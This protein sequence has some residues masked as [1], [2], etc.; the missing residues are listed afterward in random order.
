MDT[1]Q[2]MGCT[3]VY[4]QIDMSSGP[5]TIILAVG[6]HPAPLV[7]RADGR[8]EV[9][10]AC[11]TMLGAVQ[12]PAF[13]TCEVRLAAGDAIVVYSD[14]ILDTEIDGARIDEP[15]VGELL[16]GPPAATAA[17]LVGRL[18]GAVRRS[19]AP[20]RDDVAF[21]ALRCAPGA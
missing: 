9:T 15:R 14:G 10:A 8:V 21:F 7:V 17:E 12:E 2:P 1:P 13:R 18:Q 3:A 6:G 4:G 19:E 11:G 16:C 5:A 20:L